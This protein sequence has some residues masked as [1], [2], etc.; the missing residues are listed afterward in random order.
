MYDEERAQ[1]HTVKVVDRRR[2]DAGGE[3]RPGQLHRDAP[4]PA[5]KPA[6][7]PAEA[8]PS[9]TAARD[10]G[11]SA[12]RGDFLGFVAQLGTQALASM[13][14]LPDSQA[15]G[16]APNSQMAREIIDILQ[17]LAR[18]TRGNLSAEEDAAFT[19]LVT[20]LQMQFVRRTSA[21][22]S[23]GIQPAGSRRD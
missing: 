2:F 10:Q 20:D 7:A 16:I 12:D 4:G 22:T 14:A 18:R 23:A 5:P 6:A 8:P 17:M 21:D 15:R 11:D 19:R 13:G 1:A 9:A 3:V